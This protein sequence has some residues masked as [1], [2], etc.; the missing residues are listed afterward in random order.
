[1][2]GEHGMGE[3]ERMGL[4]VV[5]FLVEL[6]TVAETKNLAAGV[7]REDAVRALRLE[8]DN[9]DI[10]RARPKRGS[11]AAARKPLERFEL[12]DRRRRLDVIERPSRNCHTAPP[13]PVVNAILTPATYLR[14]TAVRIG[15]CLS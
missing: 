1:M 12:E 4:F 8:R 7:P 9:R 15:S 5:F 6:R 14:Q 2:R 13:S 10:P 3:S 11:Y